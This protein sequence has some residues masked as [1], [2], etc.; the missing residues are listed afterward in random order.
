MASHVP[1]KSLLSVTRILLAFQHSAPLRHVAFMFSPCNK[2]V[3][4]KQATFLRALEFTG[5]LAR[6][7]NHLF[8]PRLAVGEDVA[9]LWVTMWGRLWSESCWWDWLAPVWPTTPL[10]WWAPCL[11]ASSEPVAE[12]LVR[13]WWNCAGT[14]TLNA[15]RTL[16]PGKF[17]LTLVCSLC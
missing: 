1:C 3:S 10:C 16:N 9:A 4:S 17:A 12:D 8:F 6:T 11:A 7:R 13:P 15:V 14:L 2:M 5:P